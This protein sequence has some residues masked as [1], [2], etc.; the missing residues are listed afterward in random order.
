MRLL[1]LTLTIQ[2]DIRSYATTGG[3]RPLRSRLG[4]TTLSLDHFLLRSRALSLYRTI[5]R[6][7]RRI[8]DPATREETRRYARAEFERH[9]HVTDLGHI[10]YLLSTGKTE[11]EAMERYIGAGRMDMDIEA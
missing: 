5:I 6:G 8:G 1:P 3:G 11:W 2:S 9:R 10:R 7:T 4:T